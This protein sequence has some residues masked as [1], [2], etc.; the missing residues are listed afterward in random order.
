M[1]KFYIALI[2]LVHTL[3]AIPKKLSSSLHL[4]TRVISY[5][6]K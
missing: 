4:E 3:V 1:F 6:F 2:A 5:H